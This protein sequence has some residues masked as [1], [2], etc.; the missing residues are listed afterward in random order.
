MDRCSYELIPRDV[1]FFRDA[2]PID[3]DKSKQTDI[4]VIGHGAE[5]PRPDLLFSAVIHTL[6]ANPEASSTAL[7]GSVQDLQVVGPFPKKQDKLYLPIPLDWDML[8][9]EV[10]RGT[11]D[12][13]APLTHGFCDRTLAKKAYPKWI[14][15]DTYKL[16]LEGEVATV[17]DE[18]Y[19]GE[20]GPKK[21][22]TH[23]KLYGTEHRNGITL[24]DATG[25]SLRKN[26]RRDSGRYRAEYLRLE[27]D[28][29]MVCALSGARTD[30][31]SGADMVMG[32]QGGTVQ[33][34]GTAFNL[35]DELAKLPTGTPT[36]FVRWTLIAPAVFDKGWYPNWLNASGKVM[37]PAEVPQRKAYESRK[38]F[39]ARMQKEGQFFKSAHLIAARVGNPIAFSGWDTATAQKPTELAVPA[40]SAYVFECADEKEA[41]ELVKALQLQAR[42]DLGE[43]GFGIGLC[44]Y[45]SPK[46]AEN[47]N[48]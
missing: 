22:P 2:R 26:G 27:S 37:I 14:D 20:D 3:M 23:P 15:I 34:A 29:T 12:L 30:D 44:S 8:L 33:V 24:D 35:T 16:Y 47:G 11:T 10:P 46:S 41:Q 5:W 31:L 25:A 4:E 18:K 6:I 48:N 21:W 32:G 7:Y 9:E 39:R 13:P 19:P 28:V 17:Y 43:K 36:R 40:G 45:V 38:A 42:S 1:L